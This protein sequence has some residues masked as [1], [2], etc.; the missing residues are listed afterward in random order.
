MGHVEAKFTNQ[1]FGVSTE[2]ETEVETEVHEDGGME[3][4][5]VPSL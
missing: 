1:H 4:E 2:L 5:P 3:I